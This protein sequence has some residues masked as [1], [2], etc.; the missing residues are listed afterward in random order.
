MSRGP[1][2][3]NNQARRPQARRQAPIDVWRSPGTLPD[4]EPIT[5]APEPGA[6]LR[7]LGDPPLMDGSTATKY[8]NAVIQR[9]AAIAAALALSADVLAQSEED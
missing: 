7:S 2:R 4:I 8:F 9:A 1:R 3:G 6:L 5:V